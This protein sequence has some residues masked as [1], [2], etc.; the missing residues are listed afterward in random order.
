MQHY[1]IYLFLWNG[2][3]VSGGSFVHHQELKTV[4]TTSGT[5]SDLYC[6]LP[7]SWNSS[8]SS[9]TLAGS[10]NGLTK[11]P[12]LYIQFWAPD[13]GRMNRL[14]HVE[15]FTKLNKLCNVAFCWLYL[16]IYCFLSYA[17]LWR[18]DLYSSHTLITTSIVRCRTR[19]LSEVS[20]ELVS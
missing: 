2:L 12:M 14:K 8:N 17:L 1:I 16:K 9:T 4:Y 11:Y 13:D 3:H 18:I 15:H 5:L 10:S 20:A 7:L 19:L 6:Y